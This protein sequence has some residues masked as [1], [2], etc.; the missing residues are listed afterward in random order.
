MIKVELMDDSYCK[1]V[2]LLDFNI[3]YFGNMENIKLKDFSKRLLC[4]RTEF[5]NSKKEF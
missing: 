3:R 1:L 4:L 5:C 2:Q